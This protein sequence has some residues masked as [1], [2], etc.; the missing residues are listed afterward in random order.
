M[1]S[2]SG[3]GRNFSLKIEGT[4]SWGE[5]MAPLDTETRRELYLAGSVLV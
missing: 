5:N 2:H 3:K 1:S 4:D